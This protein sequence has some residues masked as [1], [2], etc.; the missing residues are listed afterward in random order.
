MLGKVRLGQVTEGGRG[1]GAAAARAPAAGGL[2]RHQQ[3][4]HAVGVVDGLAVDGRLFV[5]LALAL[6]LGVQ[7]RP[8]AHLFGGDLQ[9]RR[10]RRRRR[11]QRRG[12][13]PVATRP[14]SRHESSLDLPFL[15]FL[16]VS[17][18]IWTGFTQFYWVLRGFIGFYWVSLFPTVFYW[19]CLDLTGFTDFGEFRWDSPGFTGFNK[20]LLGFIA[21]HWV[22]HTVW[23]VS[24]S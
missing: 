24:V 12:R 6:P 3:V 16:V 7:R 20:V 4:D 5:G 1:G 23:W 2:E 21:F 9:H 15:L 13:R 8:Q 18:W 11:R 22:L 10:R 19:V 14:I 17:G